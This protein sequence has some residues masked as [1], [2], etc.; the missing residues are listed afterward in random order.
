MSQR[1]RLSAIYPGLLQMP[2]LSCGHTTPCLNSRGSEFKS[3]ER[4]NDLTRAVL[5]MSKTPKTCCPG[6]SKQTDVSREI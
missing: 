6:T 3:Q 2:H 4:S 1:V 5:A